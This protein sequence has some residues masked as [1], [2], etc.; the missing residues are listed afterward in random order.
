V[1][2]VDVGH[3]SSSVF[4]ASFL[5]DKCQILNQYHDRNLGTRDLDWTVFEFFAK[6]FKQDHDI[7]ILT[8]AKARLRLLDAIE[9]QRKVLSAN[10]EASVNVEYLA[11]D[12]DINYL[13]TRDKFE[14]I[15]APNF[16]KIRALLEKL[17]S[18]LKV[19]ISSVEI[20][21]GGTRIPAIQR[22]IQEVFQMEVSRTLNATEC[23]ARGCAIQAAMLSP[24]FKVAQYVVEDA[25]NY[26]IRCSWL[27]Q[28]NEDAQMN[29]ENDNKNNVQK[30]TSILFD[31]GAPLESVKAITFHRDDPLIDFKLHYDPV[32]EGI[33]ALLGKN[34]L[35]NS[36]IFSSL[37]YTYHKTN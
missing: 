8:N 22:V 6:M 19:Q 17:K 5:K 32:P 10:I 3:G 20:V 12:T 11:D 13:L 28:S 36:N 33:D 16:E 2:F 29:V 30:Q 25:N 15:N 18:E 37:H 24:L 4:V 21:G 26:P 27:F 23:I 31:K 14:E 9:K 1:A 34:I 7:N 35:Y